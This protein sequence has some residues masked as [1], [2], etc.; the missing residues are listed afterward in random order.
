MMV[1]ADA[2][3]K[4]TDRGFGRVLDGGRGRSILLKR[5]GK[6]FVRTYIFV[7]VRNCADI[8]LS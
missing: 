7:V 4:S 3:R 2:F 5:L 8:V 6:F 1:G